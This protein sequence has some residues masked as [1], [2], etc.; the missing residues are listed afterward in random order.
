MNVEQKNNQYPSVEDQL[1]NVYDSR[2]TDMFPNGEIAL[3]PIK[4]LDAVVDVAFYSSWDH[5]PSYAILKKIRDN[6]STPALVHIIS[7]NEIDK[8]DNRTYRLTW[9]EQREQAKDYDA[10]N[11]RLREQYGVAYSDAESLVAFAPGIVEGFRRGDSTGIYDETGYIGDVGGGYNV[12]K[13]ARPA[14]L[15]FSKDDEKI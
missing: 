1:K 9:D 5:E 10:E 8:L 13:F 6:A 4:L 3:E 11:K 7:S 14:K 2:L 12:G 15:Q